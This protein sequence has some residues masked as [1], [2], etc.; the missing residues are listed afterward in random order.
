MLKDAIGFEEGL[1][2]K[3]LHEFAKRVA[4]ISGAKDWDHYLEEHNPMSHFQDNQVPCL[5]L[6][7]L[8]DP[9]CVK[10]NIPNESYRNYAVVLTQYGSHIAFAEGLFAQRSWMERITMDFLET[11]SSKSL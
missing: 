5:I 1:Q 2:A 8:D 6:N 11:C 10:E 4:P 9:I 7:S 3:S